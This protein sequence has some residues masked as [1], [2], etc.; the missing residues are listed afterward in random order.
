MSVSSTTKPRNR[1][2]IV[3]LTV[4]FSLFLALVLGEISLRIMGYKPWAPWSVTERTVDN[5]H[6]PAMLAEKVSIRGWR[7]RP[8]SY[9]Y[10][11]YSPEVAEIKVNINADG[12]RATTTANKPLQDNQNSIYFV[13]G[14]ITM[15]FA[16]SDHETMAAKLAELYP[17]RKVFNFG[18]PG[19]GTLQSLQTLEEVLPKTKE[20]K[21][22]FYGLME[23][24][25]YRNV[26]DDAW[27][28]TFTA[29]GKGSLPPYAGLDKDGTLKRYPPAKRMPWLLKDRLAMV[30][31]AEQAYNRYMFRD[32][33][34]NKEEVFRQM[35]LEMVELGKTN[36]AEVIVLFLQMHEKSRKYFK[37][38]LTNENISYANCPK[39]EN[40]VYEKEYR[41]VG[42]GHP[43]PQMNTLFANC[44]SEYIEQKQL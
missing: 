23:H 20:K 38:V 35:M 42:E 39:V 21:I 24:H 18:V 29:P 30:L 2:S 28:N 31:L 8:G 10:S 37:T 41:V 9:T 25:L 43:N 16:I 15:G 32:R 26:L 40:T 3:I 33:N 27:I 36:N 19:Y 5:D 44:A 22:I 12:G 17:N 34:K 1:R 4:T 13:G 7:N 11:G 14:S 6:I